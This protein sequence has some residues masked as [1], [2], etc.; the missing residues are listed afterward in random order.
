MFIEGDRL[1]NLPKVN[2][3]KMSLDENI[4]IVKWAYY[5]DGKDLDIHDYTIK[6]F[7]ELASISKES[8]RDEIDKKIVDVVT[9]LYSK[10]EKNI[11]LDIKRYNQLW[12]KY[13]DKYFEMLFKFFDCFFENNVEASVGLL[14]VF[15]RN[16]DAYYFSLSV[17]IEDSKLLETTAHEILHFIWFEKCKNMYPLI[18]RE[19]YDSPFLEWKYSE[20]VTDPILNNKPFSDLFDFEEKSYDSFYNLYDG[21]ELVMDRLREIYS[22]DSDINTKIDSGYQYIKEYFIKN[23]RR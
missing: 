5:D 4:D 10:Y 9:K 8:S 18:P 12:N 13:N 16:L 23:T 11:E 7:P 20:M 17:G 15:P 2:F 6:C 1:M 22:M 21:S 3:K 19:N 14:P